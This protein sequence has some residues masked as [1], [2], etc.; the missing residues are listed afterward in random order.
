STGSCSSE[1]AKMIGMT[2]G[3]LTL[4]GIYVEEPPYIRRPTMR[5]AYCT[6]TR[7]W[8]CSMKTTRPTST[9]PTA[10]TPKKTTQPPPSEEDCLM[11]HSWVGS[12]EAI[13]VNISRDMPLPTPRSVIS[14][15]SHM[16]I[17]VAATM[18]ATMT[19]MPKVSTFG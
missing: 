14:S 15:P 3:W 9:M 17:E 16:M 1:E 10:M 11:D 8:P 18:T 13:E 19:T 5:L 7:R 6:G 2:P 4:I 12:C